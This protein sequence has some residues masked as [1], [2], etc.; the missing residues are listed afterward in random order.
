[1]SA[2]TDK[3]LHLLKTQQ[4]MTAKEIGA[5]L[6]M[7]SMGARQHLQQLH[8]SGHVSYVDEAKGRGRPSRLW[9]LAE[10]SNEHFPNRH[11]DL[12][13]QLIENITQV[14]GQ[15]GLSQV[16]EQRQQQ[17]SEH[18]LQQ[19]ASH[20]NLEEK[21]KRL[22]ELRSNEGYMASWLQHDDSYLLIEN[23]CPICAAA[24]QCQGFCEGEL[25]MFQQIFSPA[26]VQ[27]EQ[28]LLSGGIRCSY[29]I[30]PCS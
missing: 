11:A 5:R 7:T 1:M 10:K 3:I 6:S 26:K 12:T 18:Y 9:R 14:F 20:T 4:P 23:H 15:A 13:V 16:V 19:L 22:T 8:C 2:S 21:L 29:R 27:R 17:I 28:H 25:L 24:S 30:T